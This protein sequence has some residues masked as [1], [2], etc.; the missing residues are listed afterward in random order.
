MHRI[1]LPAAFLTIPAICLSQSPNSSSTLKVTT[2]LV[3]V[4]VVVRDASGRVVQGLTKRDFRIS[5]DGHPQ[6]LDFFRVQSAVIAASP[7]SAAAGS[8]HP[9]SGE[10]FSNIPDPGASA[11]AINLVLLDLLNTPAL[12]QLYARRQMLKFL[13]DLP[14]GRELALFVLSDRLRLIQNFT[15]SSDQLAAAAKLLNPKDLR[16]IRSG[17]NRQ[18]TADYFA[19]FA[20]AVGRDPGG[21]HRT[22]RL[23]S[24]GRG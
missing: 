24:A 12:D 19:T 9:A 23:S 8:A 13:Q 17:D 7:S 20:D 6:Q 11:G 2:R 3:Y 10:T 5:E 21:D 14:A 18:Q 1:F 4:D 15:A 16:L 22:A